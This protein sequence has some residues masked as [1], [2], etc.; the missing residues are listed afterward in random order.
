MRIVAHRAI[1]G[2]SVLQS[3]AGFVLDWMPHEPTVQRRASDLMH[4]A[5]MAGLFE[6][7]KRVLI[8]RA[9][10][11]LFTYSLPCAPGEMSSMDRE[12]ITIL[13]GSEGTK[14]AQLTTETASSTSRLK[15]VNEIVLRRSPRIK[16]RRT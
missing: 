14:G 8:A 7:S 16:K 1:E 4:I 9:E 10:A 5:A 13:S 11:A 15:R 12:M 6:R 2:F 3:P